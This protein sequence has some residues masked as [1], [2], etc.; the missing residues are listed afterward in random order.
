MEALVQ[1]IPAIAFSLK[2]EATGYELVD[3]EIDGIIEKLL[4]M[5]IDRNKVWNVNFPAHTPDTFKG[6]LWDRVP[7]QRRYREPIS[8]TDEV[9][10]A[11]RVALDEGYIS[12]G[13]I[14]NMALVP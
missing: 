13:T 1:R 6:I 10:N 4:T 5:K 7:S 12:I 14:T 3:Q 11:D 8:E 9:E 2:W